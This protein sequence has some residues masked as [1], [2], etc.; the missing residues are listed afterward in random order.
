MTN[1]TPLDPLPQVLAFTGKA[2]AGKSTAANWILRNHPKAMKMSFAQPLKKMAYEL[3]R[4]SI[5][6]AWP[7]TPSDYL[8]GA[9]KEEPIPFLSDKSGRELMQSLG[10][11][12]GR[13]IV[14]KDFWVTIASGKLERMLG[15]PPNSTD[16]LQ[17][18]AVYDDVRFQNEVD[19]IRGYGGIVVHIERPLLKTASDTTTNHASE[20]QAIAP[21]LVIA[22][23]GTQEDFE[24]ALATLLPPPQKG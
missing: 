16:T 15:A 20:Q 1:P 9:L 4:Q 3:I 23:A 19:M 12:W 17:I 6:K 2:G 24:A 13:D 10:T 7:H 11:E 8:D 22:N 21:D 18:K 5:P 14:H